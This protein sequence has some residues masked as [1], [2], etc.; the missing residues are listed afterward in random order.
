M[1]LIINIVIIALIVTLLTFIYSKSYNKLIINKNKATN[2]WANIVKEINI[3]LNL[4][5]QLNDVANTYLD[6]QTKQQVAAVTQ[7]YQTKVG[8]EDIINAYYEINK[9]I[10]LILAKL[11]NQEW[12]QAFGDSFN[13][14]EAL[15]KEYNDTILKINNLVKMFPTSLIAKV[16]SITPWTFFR[17]ID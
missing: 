13:R 14:I 6:D 3:R 15:R 2:T 16:N 4:L 12:N 7:S 11:N 8:V 1:E 9:V 5:G 17:G 10:D